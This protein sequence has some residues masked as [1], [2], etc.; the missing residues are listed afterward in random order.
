MHIWTLRSGHETGAEWG[1]G[2][3]GAL[4]EFSYSPDD[5]P[6]TWEG[7]FCNTVGLL[8]VGAWGQSRSGGLV[9]WYGEAAWGAGP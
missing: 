8:V 7:G 4:D 2:A 5:S 9:P 3:Q 6:L 1:L